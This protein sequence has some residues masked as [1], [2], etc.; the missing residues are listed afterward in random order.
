LNQN[1]PRSLIIGLGLF[2]MGLAGLLLELG[3]GFGKVISWLLIGVGALEAILMG[4]LPIFFIMLLATPFWIMSYYLF[5]PVKKKGGKVVDASGSAVIAWHRLEDRMVLVREIEIINT[6]EGT[7]VFRDQGK[8]QKM[9]A[10]LKKNGVPEYTLDEKRVRRAA[11]SWNKDEQLLQRT[12]KNEGFDW[13]AYKSKSFSLI[14][15]DKYNE[16]SVDRIHNVIEA[17]WKSQKYRER[18]LED[19]IQLA[20]WHS[21]A[22]DVCYGRE[23]Q[24]FWDRISV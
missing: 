14:H 20:L 17:L 9:G 11:A 1:K 21:L 24:S 16:G 18:Q 23:D 8:L 2:A 6:I 3:G 15:L 10:F 7:S 13:K 4:H 12:R 5:I 22:V 19:I